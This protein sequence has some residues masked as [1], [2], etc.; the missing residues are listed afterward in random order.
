M[1]IYYKSN[2]IMLKLNSKYAQNYRND[3][4]YEYQEK[5]QASKMSYENSKYNKPEISRHKDIFEENV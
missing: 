1:Y 2:D 5:P 3:Q 4:D